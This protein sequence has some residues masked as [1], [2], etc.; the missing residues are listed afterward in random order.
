[1]SFVFVATAVDKFSVVVFENL[2]NA[3]AA[4]PITMST[5]WFWAILFPGAFFIAQKLWR[6][7]G[8]T[9]MRW[10]TGFRATA[11]QLLFEY[12]TL[13]S[14]DY[15]NSRFSGS[16]ASKISNAVDGI[17]NLTEKVLWRFLPLFLGILWYIFYSWTSDARLGV[18]IVVWSTL[19]LCANVWFG[20]KLQPYS[21]A[22]AA[23]ASTLK[24]KIVD[25]LSNISL[26]HEYAYIAGERNYIKTYVDK[27]RRA[28][29]TQWWLSEWVLLINGIL[30]SGFMMLMIG[31][32]VYLY[33]QHTINIGVVVM[34]VVIVADLSRQLF[35]LGQEI[36]DAGKFFGQA[37]EGLEEI[38]RKHTIVDIPDAPS[39]MFSRGVIAI[40]L[41]DFEYENTK[42]FA[43]F[44][45][46]IPAGQKIGLVGKSGAGKTTLASLLLRHFDVQNGVITIDGQNITQVRLDS[47]RRA[48]AFVPQD[49]SLFHRSIKEIFATA[50]RMQR[51][52]R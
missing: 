3:I 35:F 33:Q 39:L 30:I 20:M 21:Y 51:K 10:L 48:I 36:R 15:F 34:I 31:T 19:F 5:V 32:S 46:T 13:H 28:E 27:Q 29:A 11:Y 40:D 45:L 44:S 2:S 1:M 43:N 17:E 12:L 6:S 42:V 22:V 37:R 23:A 50:T 7:S 8:F 18:I 24:G 14:K 26:V 41:I 4:S 25:A 9:G 49:T 16:L 38:L 52:R 47:L